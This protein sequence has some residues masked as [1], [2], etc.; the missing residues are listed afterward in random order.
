MLLKKGVSR[1]EPPTLS[2]E[3]V[4]VP[5]K[6][7]KI[8]RRID[9]EDPSDWDSKIK[10]D[11]MKEM[12]EIKFDPAK[13]IVASNNNSIRDVLDQLMDKMKDEA[14]ELLNNFVREKKIAEFRVAP[15]GAVVTQ[16]FKAGRVSITI[17][18]SGKVVDAQQG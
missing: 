17:D 9:S 6:T 16:D 2:L 7:E 3:E 14:V 11:A 8:F 4:S 18:A 13:H 15:I 12:K 5:V 10:D 1:G